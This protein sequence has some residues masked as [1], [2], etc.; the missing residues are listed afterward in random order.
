VG[1]EV[2]EVRALFTG[3][4][5]VIGREALPALVDAGI[6]VTA[7]VREGSDHDWI[8]QLGIGTASVDLFD[9]DAVAA[10][11]RGH[12]AVFH[13]ATAIPPGREFTKRRAWMSNDRLRAEATGL[14][15]DVAL[16]SDVSFFVQESVSFVYADGGDRWLDETARVAPVWDVLDSAL[17]A[18][19][20]VQRFAA[21]GRTGVTLRLGRLYGPGR[22]SGDFIGAVA[23]GAIPIVGDGRNFVSHLHVGDAGAAVAAALGAPSGVYNV[24]DGHPVMSGEELILLSA[25]LGRSRPRRL[26]FPVARG[27]VGRAAR[28]LTVS[29]RVSI[30]RF[31]AETGWEPT[32]PS[33]REGWREVLAAHAEMA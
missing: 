14:L 5:G 26:P 22:A 19:R 27:A 33:I 16:R 2:V 1:I 9:P 20:H 8:R 30:D 23:K 13:F 17:A 21:A 10:A 4:T 15:V 6:E 11:L 7:V 3:A 32:H 28:L 31:R 12:D 29:Q 24:S 18:E 25:L